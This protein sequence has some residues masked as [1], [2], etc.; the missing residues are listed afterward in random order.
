MLLLMISLHTD[1]LPQVD[2][3]LLEIVVL[4]L[5]LRNQQFVGIYLLEEGLPLFLNHRPILVILLLEG[6][7]NVFHPLNELLVFVLILLQLLRHLSKLDLHLLQLLS[8]Y[9][10]GLSLNDVLNSGRKLFNFLL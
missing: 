4:S 3:Q 1:L 6:K 8:Q 7:L 2:H 9:D 10:R 5:E